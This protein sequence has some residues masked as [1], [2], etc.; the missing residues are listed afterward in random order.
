MV[1]YVGCFKFF[2]IF[3]LVVVVFQNGDWVY[4][5]SDFCYELGCVFNYFINWELVLYIVGIID[6]LGGVVMFIFV[7]VGII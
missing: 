1:L 3:V 7:I 5:C 6:F 4:L 2:Y